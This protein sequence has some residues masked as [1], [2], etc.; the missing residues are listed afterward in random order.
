MKKLKIPAMMLLLTLLLASCQ[1]SARNVPLPVT[2]ED[3]TAELVK[4]PQFKA[5]AQAAPDFV[6]ATFHTI[7]RLEKDKANA[8]R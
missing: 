3:N 5:A 2:A 4:H 6:K 7:H 8:G 1:S